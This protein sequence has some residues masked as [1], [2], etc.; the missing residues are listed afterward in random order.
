[1][2][3]A[4]APRRTAS[5]ALTGSDALANVNV[6]FGHSLAALYWHPTWPPVLSAAVL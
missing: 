6:Q 4:A 3:L 2:G 5:P 1:M